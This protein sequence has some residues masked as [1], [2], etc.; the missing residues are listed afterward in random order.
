MPL[1]KACA[2]LDRLPVK[3]AAL[4]ALGLSTGAR[5]SEILA[6]RRK[7]LI[8][9]DGMLKSDLSM[10]RLK[11]GGGRRQRDVKLYGVYAPYVMRHLDAESRRGWF[12]ADDWVFRGIQGARLS[13]RAAWSFFRATLG[14]GFGTHWMRKTHARAFYESLLADD[15]SDP[16]RA[17]VMAG[18]DL[19]HARIENT[20]KY[21]GFDR[22]NAD[23]V[24]DRTFNN[25]E[26]FR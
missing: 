25:K 21:L 3:Y 5:I 13:R 11:R 7:D 8:G 6:L 2:W 12:W 17:L 20:V 23:R 24:R 18:N 4:T 26:L 10:I 1:K 19:G 22:D 16:G 14:N 9:A 15:P